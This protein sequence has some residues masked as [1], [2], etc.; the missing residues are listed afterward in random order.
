[1]QKDKLQVGVK[2]PF[3]FNVEI[4]Y[5]APETVAEIQQIATDGYIVSQFIRG[6]RIALRGFAAQ[7]FVEEFVRLQKLRGWKTEAD[8]SQEDRKALAKIAAAKAETFKRDGSRQDSTKLATLSE[9]EYKALPESV[10]KTLAAQGV[11]IVMG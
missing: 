2:T 7:D 6:D 8:V 3:V 11:K 10:R 4:D 9:A 5:D 1:M